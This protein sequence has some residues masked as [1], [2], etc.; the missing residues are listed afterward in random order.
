MTALLERAH[1]WVA[2]VH[3]HL[4]HLERTRDWVVELD[5]DAS[6]ALQLAALTHDIER[7]FPDPGQPWTRRSAGMTPATTAGTRTAAPT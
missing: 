1:D 4:R 5:P 7:A 2:S 6:E 3:P